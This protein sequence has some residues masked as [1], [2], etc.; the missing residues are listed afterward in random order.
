MMT[1]K[2]FN[3]LKCIWMESGFIEYKLCDLNFDCEN[4]PLDKAIKEKGRFYKS[5][6]SEQDILNKEN[7]SSTYSKEKVKLNLTLPVD[8]FLSPNHIWMKR[9]D[10]R[11]LKLG[12][13]EF[14]QKFVKHYSHPQLPSTESFISVN[15]PFIW[16]VGTYGVISFSSPVN[17]EVQTIN[18]DVKQNPYKFFNGNPFENWL[19]E[20]ELDSDLNLIKDSIGQAEY[21]NFIKQEVQHVKDFVLANVNRTI[22]GDTMQ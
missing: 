12:L 4:C 9:T 16:F 5:V 3:E 7:L 10:Q 2:N 20:V 18:F 13:D 15:K 8:Y 22:I 19:V 6:L 11:K 1:N 21:V 14:A 17:G